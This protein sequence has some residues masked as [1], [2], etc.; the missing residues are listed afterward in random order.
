MAQWRAAGPWVSPRPRGQCEDRRAEGTAVRGPWEG[1]RGTPPIP[2]QWA[3]KDNRRSRERRG[4]FTPPWPPRHQSLGHNVPCPPR[5]ISGAMACFF[6]P[7]HMQ[8]QQPGGPHTSPAPSSRPATLQA[9]T[10]QSLSTLEKRQVT[11]KPTCCGVT[12]PHGRQAPRPPGPH[13][14]QPQDCLEMRSP[15]VAALGKDGW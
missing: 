3:R 5:P 2:E 4:P 8:W 11:E 14:P 1:R 10:S 6:L 15:E 12:A 9:W 7:G 13:G